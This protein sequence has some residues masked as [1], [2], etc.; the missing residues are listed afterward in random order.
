VRAA[1]ESYG[2]VIDAAAFPARIG[3]LG[4]AIVVFER[5]RSC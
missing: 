5:V 3:P 2:P 4:Y 1:F